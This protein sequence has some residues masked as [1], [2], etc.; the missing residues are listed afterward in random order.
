E[1]FDVDELDEGE[2]AL[3]V[4]LRNGYD[5]LILDVMLPK[6][7]GIEIC[8]RV[9]DRSDVPIL[10]LTARDSEGDRVLGLESGADDYVAKPFSTTCEQISTKRGRNRGLGRA[11][12]RYRSGRCSQR[13]SA[14]AP[15]GSARARTSSPSTAS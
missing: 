13:S 14:S 11:A 8:R 2:A 12:G 1:G 4:A 15:R 5:L 9:R 10:M 3:D 6:L 7:S